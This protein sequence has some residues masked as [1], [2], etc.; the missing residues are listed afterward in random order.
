MS[1]EQ[2]FLFF[3]S[4][5]RS[6]AAISHTNRTV[7]LIQISNM[8]KIGEIHLDDRTVWTM[9]FHPRDKTYLATGT[10]AGKVSVHKNT[11]SA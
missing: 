1:K 11:V 2:D 3:S 8:K 4:H 5:F 9:D 7:S 6:L 10:F